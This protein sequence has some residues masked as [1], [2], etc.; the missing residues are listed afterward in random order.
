MSHSFFFNNFPL[1]LQSFETSHVG[2]W[3]TG[4]V[5][6]FSRPPAKQKKHDIYTCWEISAALIFNL[7]LQ[8][9]RVLIHK[10]DKNNSFAIPSL[11]FTKQYFSTS[12]AHR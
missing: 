8:V 1:T 9:I 3:L 5:R 11:H 12:T 6:R 10:I 4:T 2:L 7:A